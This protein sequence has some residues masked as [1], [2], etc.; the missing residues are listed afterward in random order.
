MIWRASAGVQRAE[1]VRDR[2]ISRCIV[3]EFDWLTEWPGWI[4]LLVSGG[5][6]PCFAKVYTT[7]VPLALFH[8]FS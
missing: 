4:A 5:Y 2:D 3:L 1:N 6:T 7:I 8:T